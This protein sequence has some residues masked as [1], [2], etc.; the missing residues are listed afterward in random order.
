[1]YKGNYPA[2][3]CQCNG[4]KKRSTDTNERGGAGGNNRGGPAKQ[5]EGGEHE[6]DG[7]TWEDLDF[8]ALG[9]LELSEADYY[10]MTAA[11]L[12]IRF[13]GYN[14]KQRVI[15]ERFRNLAYILRRTGGGNE[16]REALWPVVGEV[17]KMPEPMTTERAAAIEKFY[18]N[19]SAKA[20]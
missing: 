16:T 4:K 15:D 5:V 13:E 17:I 7:L 18:N 10:H 6:E 12:L 11:E 2:D 14:K 19:Y 3:T 1:M 8:F 20:K 9:I